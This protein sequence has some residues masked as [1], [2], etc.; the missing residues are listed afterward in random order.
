MTDI[1]DP[2]MLIPKYQT[3]DDLDVEELCDDLLD[4]DILSYMADN[5]VGFGKVQHDNDDAFESVTFIMQIFE[6]FLEMNGPN[7][8]AELRKNAA[9]VPWLLASILHKE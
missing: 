7:F 8:L 4:K 1:T 2:E 3:D 6:H 5:L 9:I